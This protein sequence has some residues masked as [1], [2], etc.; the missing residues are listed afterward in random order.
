[1]KRLFVEKRDGFNVQAK[2]VLGDLRNNVNITNLENVR[3]INR[4]D[5][6]NLD[7]DVYGIAK[8]T[9]F[10][11]PNVDVC[12]DEEISI[13][14]KWILPVE[15]L[16][17]Q[18]D[19]RANS[20]EEC[21]SIIA[22]GQKPRVKT[23]TIY[24]FYGNINDA[25]FAKIGKYLINP[26]ES[27]KAKLEKPESLV[28]ELDEVKDVEVLVGFTTF[29]EAQL[30]NFRESKG[31]SMTLLDLK[32][33][34]D[35]FVK[36]ENRD[37][38]ITEIKVI[39]TYWS[40]HCRHTTF[41]TELENVTFEDDFIQAAFEEYKDL[42]EK[43]NIKKP[44]CLMDLATIGAKYLKSVGKLADLDESDEINACSIKITVDVDGKD[45]PYLLMFKNETHNHPTEIEPFGG[46]ATC[47]G[48]AIRDPLSGRSYVY[49][50]MRVT[51][52]A[53][54][55]ETIENT[56]EGKLPQRIITTKAAAGYSS[57]GNQIGLTT[58][59]VYEIYD[60]GYK[61][62]RLEVGAV[63]GAAP[64]ENV[65]REKPQA[66]DM[67]LLLGGRTG[68]DGIGGAT[69]SSKIHTEKSVEKNSSEV[70]KG[71]PI[72]ERKIQRLFRNADVTKLI[73]KC[74]DFGAGGVC[75]AIG[76]LADSLEINLDV[77]PKKYDGLDGTELAI[78]ESQERM[79]IVIEKQNVAKFEEFCKEENLEVTHVATVTDTGRLVMKW[80]D[81][82]IFSVTREFLDT[83]GA[84]QTT[85]VIVKKQNVAT[86]TE[87]GKSKTKTQKQSLVEALQNLN[88]CS[89]KGLSENFDSTIGAASVVMPF[90]GKNMITEPCAMV[91]K[92]PVLGA[93]TD[94]CSIMSYGYNPDLTKK[95]TFL[96]GMYAVIESLVKILA[97]GGNYANARLS[98]QEY[99]ERMT[100]E[101][102]WGKPLS[103]LLGALKAQ[104]ELGTAAIGGKDSMSGT[105]K[106]MNVPETLISFA[107]VTEKASKI[108]TPELKSTNSS[109]VVVNFK[110]DDN[111]IPLW[112]DL[113]AKYSAIYKLMQEGKI[114][115]AKAVTFGGQIAALTKMAMGNSI[116][117]ELTCC[118]TMTKEKIGAIVLEVED[119]AILEGIEHKLIAKTNTSSVITFKDKETISLAECMEL[120]EKPLESVFRTNA[121]VEGSTQKIS[122]TGGSTIKSSIK[123][124]KPR[125]FIP[126]FPGTN[127]E[128]DTKHAFDRAG[129]D[130]S[131]FIFRNTNEGDIDYSVD[132]FVKHINNSQIIA[133]PGGFSAGD[134]P[135][136][137]A[138]FITCV[139]RNPKI[140]EAV[141]NMLYK[142]DGLMLGICNGFQALIKLGLLPK[143]EI[144]TITEDMPTLTFNAITRHVS[145][146]SRTKVVSNLSPWMAGADMN[147]E[148]YIP[149]SHGEGRFVAND[150]VLAD[151]I[152]HGQVATQYVDV[153]GNPS[154]L[155]KDNP[156]GSVCAIEGITS[157]DGRILGKMGHSERIGE[158]LYKN[159][160]GNFDQKIFESGVAYFG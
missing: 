59:G 4:Y 2:T 113:H 64:I 136:G 99:F 138:K 143:G 130:A 140:M 145:C 118:C 126:A 127:C 114:L 149:M 43:L 57:Y 15:F 133:L 100:K 101:E 16:P 116:G 19:A 48:G 28:Q 154:M 52:A 88:V 119:V 111:G 78:S 89:K 74:N 153:N 35:Y 63:I 60:E 124:A 49:Q 69:G 76:E 62:K 157:K 80:R 14:T 53:D 160:T 23:A 38:S 54:P 102:S 46:A 86:F 41:M 129:A 104:K 25:D 92:I 21:V 122:Y 32:M 56:M 12:Y 141:H 77:V 108:I 132:Q 107:V 135:D 24:L 10:S 95:S 98:F 40:D 82:A 83:N 65:V 112:D 50:A 79:A 73:K 51:G 97:V 17:G 45:V 44:I 8:D 115:S 121:P 31:L 110:K 66:G 152:A 11:E 6:E 30:D 47:L 144:S 72:V 103:A 9:I 81:K 158:N 84:K 42:R 90:G 7:D 131:V 123:I 87:C 134:E 106:D 148:Y 139:F 1:M 159:I 146:L 68:R 37:P 61:A 36:N 33:I 67:I 5:I 156:N 71:N 109:I 93:K 120:Y 18:F 39:D 94:T 96:G 22:H 151:L 137:S 29:N 58:G 70:Q 75:V 142:R 91:A 20:A 117:F 147:D 3:I 128:M 155:T 55:R 27:H 150:A 125:V 26:V 85:D 34:Q 13:D 105:F